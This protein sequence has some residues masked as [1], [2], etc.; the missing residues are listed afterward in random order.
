MAMTKMGPDHDK[1]LS[2]NAG[3]LYG[4]VGGDTGQVETRPDRRSIKV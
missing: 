2:R 1:P 3:C 4:R